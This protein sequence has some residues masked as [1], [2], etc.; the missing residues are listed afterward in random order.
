MISLCIASQCWAGGGDVE[1]NMLLE[2]KKLI[3][4]QQKQLDY[5]AKQIAQLTE[6]LGGGGLPRPLSRKRTRKM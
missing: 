2:L 6:Q 5:Q 4:Q 3:E 1:A